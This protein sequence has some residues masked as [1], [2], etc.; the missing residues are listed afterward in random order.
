ML[1]FLAQAFRSLNERLRAERRQDYAYA[2]HDL[3]DEV[4]KQKFGSENQKDGGGNVSSIDGLLWRMDSRFDKLDTIFHATE[5]IELKDMFAPGRCT[6]L[7]LSDIEQHEQQVIVGTL[8]APRQQSPM[9]DRSP[10][11]A[12]EHGK[13]SAVSGFHSFG[14]S[15]PFRA[16]RSERRLDQYPETN[17]LRRQK[18]RR[19]HRANHAATGQT[20]PGRSLA[21]YDANHYAHRQPD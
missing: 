3:R 13:S 18:I 7:Q 8:L 17:S 15:A 4:N 2:Y 12:A 9:F 21:M 11:S 5:H 14:R 1:H 6:I 16:R 10:G 19:R 20:R